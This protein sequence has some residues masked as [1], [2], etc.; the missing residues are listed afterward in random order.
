MPHHGETAA[1]TAEE[2]TQLDDLV[3]NGD[4]KDWR[5]E[6]NE[7]ILVFPSGAELTVFANS[8]PTDEPFLDLTVAF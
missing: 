5:S 8:G 6:G 2:S 3:D 4:L 7:L 1:V